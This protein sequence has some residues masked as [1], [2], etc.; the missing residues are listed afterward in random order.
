MAIFPAPGRLFAAVCAHSF[1][2]SPTA[3]LSLSALKLQPGS[4]HYDILILTQ[5]L[6]RC[7]YSVRDVLMR[8][9]PNG[10]HRHSFSP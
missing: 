9:G 10:G 7:Q 4:Q 5:K 2:T 3:M 8:N 1:W 6:H